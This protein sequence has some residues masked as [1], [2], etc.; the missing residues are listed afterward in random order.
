LLSIGCV[1]AGNVPPPG[2]LE[3]HLKI[4]ALKEVDLADDGNVSKTV[5]EEPML[6]VR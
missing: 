2:F 1:A 4:V 5:T 6:N 3:G